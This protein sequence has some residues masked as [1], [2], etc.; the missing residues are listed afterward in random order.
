MDTHTRMRN[1]PTMQPQGEDFITSK[2]R[3]RHDRG[4]DMHTHTD[5]V[6]HDII[7][8]ATNLQPVCFCNTTE[9][10]TVLING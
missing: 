10:D 3:Q 5:T 9:G 4:G 1:Q 2:E 6:I 8:L 7:G